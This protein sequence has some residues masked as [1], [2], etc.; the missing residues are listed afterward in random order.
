MRGFLSTEDIDSN[1]NEYCNSNC[2]CCGYPNGMQCWSDPFILIGSCGRGYY[3][4]K[5]NEGTNLICNG[6]SGG[7]I[8][9]RDNRTRVLG[10]HEGRSMEV[11]GRMIPNTVILNEL[12]RIDSNGK[13]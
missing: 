10:I 2:I 3:Q 13:N 7:I 12:E 11:I 8:V 4:T 6:Y 5:I 9:L 1:V